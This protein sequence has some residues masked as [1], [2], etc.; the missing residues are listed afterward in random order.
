MCVSPRSMLLRSPFKRELAIQ[1]QGA[2]P[3]G[4]PPVVTPSGF[5]S[6]MELKPRFSQ[7]SPV[8]G[9]AWQKSRD[10]PFL[11]KVRLLKQQPFSRIYGWVGKTARSASQSVGF[12]CLILFYL[13][14]TCI[15]FTPY[16]LIPLL[17]PSPCWLCRGPID[18][19]QF[20][21]WLLP[22]LNKD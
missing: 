21:F 1:G 15:T 19:I 16:K 6:A 11:P 5:T 17:T 18:T 22:S 3:A 12:H 7:A 13:F 10:W 8:D 4:R 20:Y 14:L 2:Q 9:S